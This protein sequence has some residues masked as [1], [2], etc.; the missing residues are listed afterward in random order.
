ML[1]EIA[2]GKNN[3]GVAAGLGL[4]ERMVEK[5]INSLFAKLGLTEEPDVHRR[6]SAVLLYLAERPVP[7]AE[8]GA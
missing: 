8:T 1:G 4:S 5:H 2:R 7:R 3:A 6:V